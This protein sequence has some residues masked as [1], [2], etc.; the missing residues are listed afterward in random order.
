[1][2][3]T[4]RYVSS[5]G[6]GAHDGSTEADAYSLSEFVTAFN[7]VS[8]GGIRFN[9][10]QD[11]Y[12]GLSTMTL[13]GDGTATSPIII[14]G[15]KT[16]IGDATRGRTSLGVLDTSNMPHLQFNSNNFFD[17]NGANFLIVE[18][19]KITTGNT[20]RIGRLGASSEWIG[21]DVN[22]TSSGD[23]LEGN[24]PTSVVQCDVTIASTT[25]AHGINMAGTIVG[26]RVK[27]P[28]TAG[29]GIRLSGANYPCSE[30]V[31]IGFTTG[32]DKITAAAR[33]RIANNTIVNCGGNGIT[34][35]NT[36]TIWFGIES[37][38][39]TG[40]GG[41]GI[42]LNTPACPFTLLNNRMR[43]N[44]GGGSG[45]NIGGG[46]DWMT[47]GQQ[48]DVV[49]DDSDADDFVDSGSNDF[50]LKTTAA[51]YHRGLAYL[52][53]IG[54]NGSPAGGGS[55]IILNPGFGGGFNG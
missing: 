18:A 41:Y 17:A 22:N 4:E 55:G 16:T 21:C 13:T 31:I 15:Y 28:P 12:T 51:A 32:I 25:G 50:S 19:V 14:R 40:C 3:I 30:N 10:K 27:G 26:C 45:L 54:A 37:N 49:S 52:T 1:M 33:N 44:N 9:L 42:Q 47:A 39:I 34:I 7:A 36:S 53:N 11:T 48:R 29:T 38:H 5:A 6:G 2:A 35:V 23:G 8:T 20:S 24:E 43:D 46:G